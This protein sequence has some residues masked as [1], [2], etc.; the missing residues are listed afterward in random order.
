[1]IIFKSVRWKNFLSTGNVFSEIQLDTSPATLI[2]GANGAGKSTFLDAMCYALFD[3][4]F[5]K[6]TKGQLVNA[7]NEKDLLVELEFAI[8]SREY[9]VRRGRKPNLFEI[10][11]NGE[12]TKE[13]AS[14]LEQQ[15]YLE[16]SILGLNYKSFTQVVVLGSSC[17]VPFMQLTPPNRRE[18][19]E[20]LLDIRIFSTMNGILKERCKGIRENIRE[21]EYQFELAKNKVETQQALIE[22]LKEQSNANTTRRKAEIKNIEKEIQDIT[23]LVDKDLDL[24]KSY[25]ESLVEYQTVDTDLSQLRIYESR[26]KDKQKS[27]KKEY[28]FFE[29]NEHCP[30]C[31][32]TITEELRTNKKSGITDQLKEVEE[33]TEKLR[34]ELDSI[35][36]K[37]EEKNDIAKE[38]SRCQ[39]AISESQREIQYR[40]RQIKAIEKKIDEA[41][42]SGSSLKKEKDKLKQLAKDGLKVE[43]S[44]LDEKR[45]R[46][47]YN[48]VTNMLKDTGIKSTIIRK[49]LPI[50]NQLINRYLKELDFYVSFELDEN[51][52]ETIKSRFRDEFSYAS[53]SE[54]EKMRIDLALLFT[55]RTIAKMKNSAN[56]NLLILD[57]IFDSS[58]D[59][60]GTDD[61]LKILHTVSDKTN[62]FVISHKTESLQDKFASTLKVEKK[63]N[64]SVISKEE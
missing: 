56:T 58:L 46:D 7:V 64:F 48:T 26:F 52:M 24:S 12:K 34:G 8:G 39:Q 22:H 5:R 32:Q 62:V 53:F 13:E 3:K 1:M 40:K 38:L 30:T 10:Y 9:M 43:E 28:K 15:K 51:F 42:G 23:I 20:D 31:Q 36:V 59:T 35:L 54:G 21:V 14:T 49:Y 17:F 55:W 4:P 2:V 16:Q 37:I 25:E 27:F 57:E 29:S 18:V 44:L 6:I 33:A 45:V 61:F 41:T 50:M 63:Q 47:N 60:S 19:I 11:L